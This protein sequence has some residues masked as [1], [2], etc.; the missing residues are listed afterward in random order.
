VR[1]LGEDGG[2][3]NDDWLLSYDRWRGEVDAIIVS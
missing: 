1:R 2:L 3:A